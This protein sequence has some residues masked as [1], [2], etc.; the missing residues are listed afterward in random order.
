[1]I[2]QD[3]SPTNLS[4]TNSAEL[5]ILVAVL[6]PPKTLDVFGE[7]VDE[8]V[9]ETPYGAV[10]PL[11][12]RTPASGPSVWV[13]PYTG[14]PTRTDPRAMIYAAQALGVRSILNWDTGIAINP[15][16]QRGQSVIAVDFIDWTRHQPLTFGSA[17]AADR[18]AARG[19]QPPAF[20]PHMVDTLCQVLPG[21]PALSIWES[22][23][24][25]GKRL[26]NL[27]C[28]VEWAPMSAA[29]IWSPKYIWPGN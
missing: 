19:L 24:Q 16:L 14:T 3:D 20:C 13:Q 7:L 22:M 17:L 6:L 8:R 11:G 18:A 9:V 28:F 15:L 26:P 10:K 25:I 12:L 23:V 4:T 5:L 2:R 27:A 21:P 1:M 29:K